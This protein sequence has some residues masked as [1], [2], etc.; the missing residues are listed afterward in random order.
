MTYWTIGPIFAAGSFFGILLMLDLG[1]RLRRRRA[2]GDGGAAG[3]GAVEGAVFALMGLLV[4]FTFS[5][6]AARFDGRRQL[7]VEEANDLGT[8]YLRLDLLPPGPR[9][10]VQETF[11]RYVD[12]RLEAYRA[13]QDLGVVRAK[14]AE[15][16]ALQ[17]EMWSQAVAG[18]QQQSPQ[19]ACA[20]LLLPAL[21]AVF[22]IASTRAAAVRLHPPMVIYGM[23]SVVALACALLAGFSMGTAARRSWLHVVGFAA[24]LALTIWVTVDLEYPRLGLIRVDDF[25][26]LLIDVRAGMR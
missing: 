21:N 13:I 20:V 10:A 7:I 6:A 19:T 15:Y 5:G 17:N 23:L 8:A 12:T 26:Q 25:D 16:Q 18:C 3:M 14:V 1:R 22:D 9:A 4:A 24:I 2:A 11:R